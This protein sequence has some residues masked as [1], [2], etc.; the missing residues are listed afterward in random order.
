M[1]QACLTIELVDIITV[2]FIFARSTPWL[3][4]L[5]CTTFVVQR[6]LWAVDYHLGKVRVN[7]FDANSHFGQVDR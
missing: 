7:F 2:A 6:C 5:S 4:W 3:A 1:I